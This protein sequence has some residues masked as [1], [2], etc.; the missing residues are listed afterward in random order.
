M[1]KLATATSAQLFLNQ[2]GTQGHVVF[3]L[4]FLPSLRGGIY[5]SVVCGNNPFGAMCS[6]VKS[7]VFPLTGSR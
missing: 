5:S 1:R 4:H 6:D 3:T 2:K 7:D